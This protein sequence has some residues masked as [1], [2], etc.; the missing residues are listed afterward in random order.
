M[1][2]IRSKHAPTIAYMERRTTDGLS[3]RETMRCLKRYVAREIYNGIRAITVTTTTTNKKTNIALDT[4]RH[5]SVMR[6]TSVG[7]G[8][9]REHVP[10]QRHP[11][12]GGQAR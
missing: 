10:L 11:L 6:S 9:K 3:K 1:V 4:K 8:S 5:A 7:A 12:D 2:R